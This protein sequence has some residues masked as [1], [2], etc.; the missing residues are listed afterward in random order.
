M[1]FWE[2]VMDLEAD[3]IIHKLEQWACMHGKNIEEC[4]SVEGMQWMCAHILNSSLCVVAK[5]KIQIN[6][7]NFEVAIKEKYGIDLLGWPEGMP[8]QSPHAI[9]NVKNLQTLHD[10]LKE[11]MCRWAYMTRQQHVQHQEQLA[12]W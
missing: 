6:F 1:D 5:K 7:T 8:F 10:A 9:T 11:G 2:D 12:E 4:N 3:E